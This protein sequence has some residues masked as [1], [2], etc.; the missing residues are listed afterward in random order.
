MVP[1]LVFSGFAH[2]PF[3]RNSEPLSFVDFP[4]WYGHFQGSR[5]PF[6]QCKWTRLSRW[7]DFP[8]HWGMADV[9][10]RALVLELFTAT[11]PVQGGKL[12]KTDSWSFKHRWTIVCTLWNHGQIDHCQSKCLVSGLRLPSTR[13]LMS[14]E[15]RTQGHRLSCQQAEAS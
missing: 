8:G 5:T 1:A 12:W 3:L 14:L 7:A 4:N 13:R 9:G 2:G 6:F 10:R 15:I 11:S